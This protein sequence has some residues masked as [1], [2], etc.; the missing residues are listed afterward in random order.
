V[1]S[2]A[3]LGGEAERRRQQAEAKVQGSVAEMRANVADETV[4]DAQTGGTS[5]L[6]LS[7][8]ISSHRQFPHLK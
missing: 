1:V 4:S 2:S 5:A 8:L 7:E 3:A 6:L